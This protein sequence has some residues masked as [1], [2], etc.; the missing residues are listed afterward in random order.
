MQIRLPPTKS[1]KSG[2]RT[3]EKIPLIIAIAPGEVRFES[4]RS[5]IPA[6]IYKTEE[7]SRAESAPGVLFERFW[8]PGS[9]CPKFLSAFWRSW[10]RKSAKK[11]S[12]STLWRTRSQVPKIAQKALWG[13][14]SG[15]GPGAL[16]QMAAGI[17]IKDAHS[18]CGAL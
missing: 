1:S 15:P 14:L 11:H 2:K 12:K 17:A 10:G 3:L 18:P 6:T 7:C 4:Q 16:L 13:A 9:E 5:A 8:A